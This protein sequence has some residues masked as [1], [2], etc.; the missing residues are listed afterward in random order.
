MLRSAW[1]EKSQNSVHKPQFSRDR[2]VERNGTLVCLLASRECLAT[3]PVRLNLSI[4]P[5][6]VLL[7]DSFLKFDDRRLWKEDYRHPLPLFVAMELKKKKK[8]PVCC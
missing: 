7:G 5:G 6:A 2:G 1:E 3:K 8:G 4:L